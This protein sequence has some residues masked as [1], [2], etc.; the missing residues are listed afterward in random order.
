MGYGREGV[1]SPLK[2]S[3]RQSGGLARTCWPW[4]LVDS[5]LAVAGGAGTWTWQGAIFTFCQAF[6]GHRVAT[7]L[8]ADGGVRSRWGPRSGPLA[9]GPLMGAVQREIF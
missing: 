6:G 5:S 4:T 7:G 1:K 2:T 8:Q 3:H 9:R